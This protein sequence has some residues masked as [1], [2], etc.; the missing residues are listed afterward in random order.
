VNLGETYRYDL[1]AVDLDGDTLTYQ[2]DAAST[3]K[4]MTL[5]Q[6]GRL[7]WNPGVGNLK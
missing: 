3:A 6:R 4:G 5:D 1:R 2:L 7:V